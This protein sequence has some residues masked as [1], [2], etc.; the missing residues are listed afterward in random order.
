[1]TKRLTLF[2]LA[3]AMVFSTGCF[4]SRKSAKP[5][6]SSA[7]AGEVEETFKRRWIDKRITELTA[8]G[9]GPE[10]AR[11]QAAREFDEKFAFAEPGKK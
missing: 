6:D 7:W 2:C 10:P 3:I 9:I 11:T 5:K 4:F 1:M 8:Q